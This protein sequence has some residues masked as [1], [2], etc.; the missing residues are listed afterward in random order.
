MLEHFKGDEEFVRKVLDYKTQAVDKYKIVLTKFLDPH[1]QNVVRSVIG[2]DAAVYEEGG[3]INCENK[4][5]IICPSFYE[6]EPDDFKIKVFRVEYPEKFGVLEHKDVLGE[7]MNLGLERE[8][9]GD[10]CKNP[11]AFSCASENAEYI[12][13][14]LKKIKR[15]TV[16]LVE[17]DFSIAIENTFRKKEFVVSSLRLDKIISAL[18][19]LSRQKAADA[20]RAGEVKVNHKNIE[21]ID[22]LCNNSDIISFRRHGR[23]KL[24]VTDRVTRQNNQVVEGLFYL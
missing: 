22:Y 21:L 12:R 19:H 6:I 10:I 17:E 14:N 13:Q 7:L 15:F 1:L 11:L 5:L 18:F 3:F 4:R 20:I 8:C 16:N 2:A 23:V 24:V 9:I